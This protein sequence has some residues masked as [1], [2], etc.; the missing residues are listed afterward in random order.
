MTSVQITFYNT[1]PKTFNGWYGEMTMHTSTTVRETI[2]KE[3]N[4]DSDKRAFGFAQALVKR[5]KRKDPDHYRTNLKIE[6][7]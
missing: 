5:L 1:E 7:L 4:T 6:V 2:N 3:Y